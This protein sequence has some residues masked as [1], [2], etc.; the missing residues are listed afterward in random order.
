MH[1]SKEPAM[2]SKPIEYGKGFVCKELADKILLTTEGRTILKESD[3][4]LD[5]EIINIIAGP[6]IKISSKGKD[7][8]VISCN[9]TKVEEQIYDFKK[10]IDERL[11]TIEKVFSKIMKQ[12]KA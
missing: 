10:E 12:V 7:T 4:T 1:T 5:A 3:F 6:G 9:L 11:Q 8:L 2:Q